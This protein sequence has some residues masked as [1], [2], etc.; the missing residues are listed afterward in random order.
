MSNYFSVDLKASTQ[1]AS[2]LSLY[3]AS[4]GSRLGSYT[5]TDAA[6]TNTPTF[7]YA[8]TVRSD[9]TRAYVASQR[10]GCVS[11]LNTSDPGHIVLV[12]KLT[13]LGEPSALLLNKA[14][15]LLYVANA[16]SD[17]VSV[18]DVATDKVRVKATVLLRPANVV[19][20]PGVSPRASR[21]RPTRRPCTRPWAISM[22]WASSTRGP[23]S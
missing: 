15:T 5:F 19:N 4:D 20:L 6:K 23:M 22:L 10:D 18:A 17:T 2:T 3:R 9:G 14:Q 11:V 13:H 8:V 21:C 7:P 16:E 1:P 12:A